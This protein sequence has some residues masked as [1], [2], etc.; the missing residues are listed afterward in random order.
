M[1]GGAALTEAGADLLEQIVACRSLSQ[2]ARRRG[3]LSGQALA[4]ARGLGE[5]GATIMVFGWQPSRLTMPISI[6]AAYEQGALGRA[7]PEVAWVTL[8][9][10]GLLLVLD[11]WSRPGGR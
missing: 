11:R 6:H 5:F 9:C 1:G 7:L 10:F 3:V 4:L 8:L 2:A